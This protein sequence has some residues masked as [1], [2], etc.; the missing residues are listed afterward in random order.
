[1]AF[2]TKGHVTNVNKTGLF[3][4][5]S[6]AKAARGK[7]EEV[8]GAPSL[9]KG[10]AVDFE[11]DHC[12]SDKILATYPYDCTRTRIKHYLGSDVKLLMKII[13]CEI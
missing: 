13:S 2:T 5:F 9:V 12:H 1:M 4:L 10:R 3:P 8:A 11:A 6:F 7:G